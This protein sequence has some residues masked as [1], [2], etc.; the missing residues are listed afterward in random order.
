MFT[1]MPMLCMKSCS[2]YISEELI[3]VVVFYAPMPHLVT[4]YTFWHFLR[5]ISHLSVYFK[6]QRSLKLC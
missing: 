1:L 2:L 3:L 6:F 4:L 5:Y